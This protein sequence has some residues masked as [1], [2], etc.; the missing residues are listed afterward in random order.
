MQHIILRNTY[1]IEELVNSFKDLRLAIRDYK[2]K[3]LMTLGHIATFV[4]ARFSY[5]SPKFL[6][7]GIY[8]PKFE[9]PPNAS[10]PALSTTDSASTANAADIN[11]NTRPLLI[12]SKELSGDCA[13]YSNLHV[14]LQRALVPKLLTCLEEYLKK[15]K[16]VLPQSTFRRLSDI[17]N[18]MSPTEGEVDEETDSLVFRLPFSYGSQ[19]VFIKTLTQALVFTKSPDNNLTSTSVNEL[20]ETDRLPGFGEYSVSLQIT[21]LFI[22]RIQDL[23]ITILLKVEQILVNALGEKDSAPRS[24]VLDTQSFFNTPTNSEM[25]L[26]KVTRSIDSRPGTSASTGILIDDGDEE[27]FEARYTTPATTK[28]ARKTYQQRVILPKVLPRTD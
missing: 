20:I 14:A 2:S 9:R 24:L 5:L 7:S 28:R 17:M 1:T 12:L 13:W 11:S 15:H 27:E 16:N 18:K 26:D 4:N 23:P 10:V 25:A 6:S 21:G 22:P 3:N 19:T 8:L